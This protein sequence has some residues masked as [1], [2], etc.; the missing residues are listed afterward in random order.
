M[1]SVTLRFL[2]EA[3]SSN[4]SGKVPGGTVMKW[5]DDAGL[6]CATRWAKRH[7]VT[8]YVSGIRFVE[9]IMIGDMVEVQ[10]RLAFTGSTSMNIAVEVRSGDLKSSQYETK[11]ECLT[12]YV[13]IDSHGQALPVDAWQPETPGEVA[14]ATRARTQLDAAREAAGLSSRY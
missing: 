8:V 12:V 1:S 9:P 2:A 11:A 10:A 3:A 5:I 13:A 7:C 14:L 6:A 4:G